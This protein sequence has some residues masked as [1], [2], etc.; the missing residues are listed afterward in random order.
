M[1]PERDVRYP[2]ICVGHVKPNNRRTKVDHPRPAS[3]PIAQVPSKDLWFA[4][5]K[6]NSRN[7]GSIVSL[8][9]IATAFSQLPS[10]CNPS[11]TNRKTMFEESVSL[12]EKI[13]EN[14]GRAQ[15]E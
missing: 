15:D 11:R 5:H 1:Q 9:R 8:F 3:V 12:L 4:I 7:L 10:V 6:G 2:A 14:R 13:N